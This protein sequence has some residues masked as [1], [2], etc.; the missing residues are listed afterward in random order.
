MIT[1]DNIPQKT[2]S[3]G[4]LFDSYICRLLGLYNAIP[5]RF[6]RKDILIAT[7][8]VSS[9]D[10]SYFAVYIAGDV[11][12]DFEDDDVIYL[13]SSKIDGRYTVTDV[14]VSGGNTIVTINL[15]YSISIGSSSGYVNLITQRADYKLN[16][17]VYLP[18]VYV[19]NIHSVFRSLF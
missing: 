7:F 6:L 18:Y 16:I 10:S 13:K 2:V 12:A 9:V 17:K 4:G 1:L 14:T 15:T 11:S 3:Q 19:L 5:F 8:A